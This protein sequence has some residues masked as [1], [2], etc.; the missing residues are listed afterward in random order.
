MTSDPIIGDAEILLPDRPGGSEDTLGADWPSLKDLDSRY[1]TKVLAHTGGNISKAA[2]I[3]GV[4]RKTLYRR[5]EGE[6]QDA[7]DVDNWNV[8]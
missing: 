2:K 5:R 6:S 8:H 3:L 7:P 4:D 1:I